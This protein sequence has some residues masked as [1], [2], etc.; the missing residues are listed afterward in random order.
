MQRLI[1]TAPTRT[2]QPALA[3]L[4]PAWD[5]NHAARRLPTDVTWASWGSHGKHLGY[6]QGKG[7]DRQLV[8]IDLQA[9]TVARHTCEPIA[10]I[11]AHPVVSPDGDRL[12]ISGHTSKCEHKSASPHS[13]GPYVAILE[14]RTLHT[15]WRTHLSRRSGLPL[16]PC[17]HDWAPCKGLFAV[18]WATEDLRLKRFTVRHA[19][20]G[21]ALRSFELL[22][23]LVQLRA[24]IAPEPTAEAPCM[25]VPQ[26][27]R[28]GA[29]SSWRM[30]SLAWRASP[31]WV[32]HYASCSQDGDVN[33]VD[34]CSHQV[35]RS[36]A[37]A[38]LFPELEDKAPKA[39][40]IKLCWTRSGG[41][42]AVSAGGMTSMISLEEPDVSQTRGVKVAAI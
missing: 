20:D 8:V 7:T 5:F 1:H 15:L 30:E 17:W 39:A 31:H 42:L 23:G 4:D 29:K 27:Q 19:R 10:G 6:E 34:S 32:L 3:A 12:I 21:S 22:H 40:S 36:W 2:L 11:G 33:L 14:L 38:E 37:W 16:V 9:N 35:L 13:P 41:K 25:V 18:A 26:T 24:R 28:G